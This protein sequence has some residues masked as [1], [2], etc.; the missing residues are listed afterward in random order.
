M[1]ERDL[2]NKLS[3]NGMNPNTTTVDKIMTPFV[4]TINAN[5]T[6]VDATLVMADKKIRRLLVKEKGDI[7]GIVTSEDLNR[8][9]FLMQVKR[10]NKTILS[11]RKRK[12]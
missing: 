4:E 8:K 5:S 11:L 6:V 3:S 9:K 1:T 2:V 12:K 10:L 7:I